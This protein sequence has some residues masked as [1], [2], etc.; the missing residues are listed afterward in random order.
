[1]KSGEFSMECK[2]I[3]ENIADTSLPSIPGVEESL[4]GED[5][6][7]E[8]KEFYKCIKLLTGFFPMD[9]VDWE[10]GT[11][12]QYLYDLIKTVLDNYAAG[13]YQVSYFYAHLIFM[14]YVY[15][16]VEKVFQFRPDRMKD[17]FYPI[18]AYNGRSD[19][20]DIENYKSVYE[21]SKIP[22]KEIFK[23]FYVM[24]MDTS[25]I[26]SMSSYISSRDY[27][28]HATGEGNISAEALTQNI[29]TIKGN[30]QTVHKAFFTDFKKQYVQFL[31][32]NVCKSFSDVQ[33]N[34]EIYISENSLSLFDIQFLTNKIGLSNIRNEN[35]EVKRNYRFIKIIHCAFIDY[36]IENYA[37]TEPDNFKELRSDMY[38][39]WR[40]ENNAE[41]YIERELKI[42][43]YDCVKDGGEFPLFNCPDCDAEQMVYDE[44][45]KHYHCFGCGKDYSK[46]EL[47]RCEDCGVLMH[48]KDIPLCSECLEGKLEE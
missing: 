6:F 46:D 1:M 16:S 19:K 27:Y 2:D 11:Y 8:Q 34:I 22:E 40:Y 43:E 10:A 21:F 17:V 13:N 9:K 14:S 28:A 12:D 23:I 26:H 30:M 7:S 39:Q 42:S 15:Y 35:E 3:Y 33:N 25:Q 36:C 29:M 24:G 32:S 5:D 44:Q 48:H 47:T 41:E 38:L 4:S 37:S 45:R 31:L 18:N 20:P